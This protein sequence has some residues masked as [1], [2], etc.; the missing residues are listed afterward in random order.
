ML[1][2]SLPPP[3]G[4]RLLALVQVCIYIVSVMLGG[5]DLIKTACVT[6]YFLNS[7]KNTLGKINKRINGRLNK[8]H[9]EEKRKARE[10][11]KDILN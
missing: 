9:L 4:W 2:M 1:E 6:L 8:Y 5:R 3:Q 10:K 7:G 11:G